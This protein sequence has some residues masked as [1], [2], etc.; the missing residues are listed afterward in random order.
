MSVS[1]DPEIIDDEFDPEG[2]EAQ[3]EYEVEGESE[4]GLAGPGEI[5]DDAN[6][7]TDPVTGRR[8]SEAVAVG[9]RPQDEFHG[10]QRLWRD[11]PEFLQRGYEDPR[12][13]REN[14]S[15]L[16]QKTARQERQLSEANS[17][18]ATLT[19][20]V[21][22]VLDITKRNQQTV[23][24][25]RREQLEARRRAA[26][27]DGDT[28]AFDQVEAEL[29]RADEQAAP[30][31]PP[32]Q[33][34]VP[35]PHPAIQEFID[36]NPWWST[37]LD[38]QRA[39]NAHYGIVQNT[40]K[41]LDIDG[42]LAL[43]RRRTMADFPAKFGADPMANQPRPGA[44]PVRRPAA[45]GVARPTGASSAAPRRPLRASGFDAIADPKAREEARSAFEATRRADPGMTEAEYLTIYNDPSADPLELRRARKRP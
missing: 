6:D 32:A 12:V 42:Q 34:T 36:A 2:G 21:G 35:P 19:Q 4:D 11:W 44:P 33:P 15:K 27:A 23:A 43:A 25:Q 26:V 9:W 30:A 3:P 14:Y 29:R 16:L 17:K 38:L 40:R 24:D 18:I 5:D 22:E 13:M 20:Q 8:R 28:S 31:P 41:D 45:A 39:M 10:D 1:Y 7:P 37:D